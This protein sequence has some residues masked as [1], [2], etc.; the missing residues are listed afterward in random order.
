MGN[1]FRWIV[2]PGLPEDSFDECLASGED[3]GRRA[4]V[5]KVLGE[6]F[7]GSCPSGDVTVWQG[8]GIEL[9]F[10]IGSAERVQAIEIGVELESPDVQGAIS[11]LSTKFR[12]LEDKRFWRVF[13]LPG[14]QPIEWDPPKRRRR[15]KKGMVTLPLSGSELLDRLTRET[16]SSLLF[17]GLGE[18]EVVDFLFDLPMTPQECQELEGVSAKYTN[19]EVYIPGGSSFFHLTFAGKAH[20]G[21]RELYRRAAV[22]AGLSIA[23]ISGEHLVVEG[24]PERTVLLTECEGRLHNVWE[25]SVRPPVQEH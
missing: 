1:V 24:P 14:H 9:R 17:G 5:Q 11:A 3:L 19:V 4:H 8:A 22:Q 20:E 13:D 15:S 6:T 12:R 18:A 2:I 7:V 16:G 10:E 21:Y 23:W 25:S